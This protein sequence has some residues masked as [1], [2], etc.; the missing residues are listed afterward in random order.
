MAAAPT[1]GQQRP[2][3]FDGAGQKPGLEIWR[4][5][6]LSAIRFPAAE[7]GKFYSGDSFLVLKTNK[8]PT[9]SSL[10]WDLHFWIGNSSSQDEQVLPFCFIVIAISFTFFTSSKRCVVYFSGRRRLQ[11]RDSGRPAGWW[12]DSAS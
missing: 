2:D 8:K 1:R 9:S 10:T 5:E 11:D 6:Q 7:Y 12:S 3:E 4:I